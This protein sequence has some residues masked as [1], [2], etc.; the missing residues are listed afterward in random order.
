M[1][2]VAFHTLGCK[3]NFSETSTIARALRREGYE[4]VPFPGPADV[5]VLNTCSVTENAD[6][7]CKSLVRKV[8]R[9]SPDAFIAI[10]GCYAQLKPQEIAAIPG[11][12]L[13]L[14]AS[15][16]FKLLHH[17]KQ[18]SLDGSVAVHA[19]EVEAA[20]TFVSAWSQGGRTRTF[21]KVQDG[22]DYP[23][24][25]CTIPLARGISRSD[26]VQS[27]IEKTHEIAATGA[28]EIV[29]TG[30]N[31]GDFGKGEHG[32]KKHQHTFLQLLEQIEWQGADL[33]YR[34]SSIEPNLLSDDIISLVASSPKFMPH[35]HM[36]LQS[37]SDA[38]LGLMKRRYRTALYQARVEH[39][40]SVMPDASIGVDVISGFPGE[41]DERF[42][43]TL[44][45][46]HRLPVSYLHAFTYSE[47][48]NTP[49]AA[50]EGKVPAEI[51]TRRTNI[52]R[53][54]SAEKQSLFYSSASG[55]EAEVL[56]EADNRDGAMFGYTKNYIR[57]MTPY[58]LELAN[59]TQ[60]V[61]LQYHHAAEAMR[62][63]VIHEPQ[64][65]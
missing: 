31:I 39:I 32:N 34:I 24:S 13:V 2:T 42:E 6:K 45:F 43:E 38:I 54:L 22:C 18:A 20:D 59:T 41:T 50:M 53:E 21:L 27:I 47:R 30:V 26:T 17:L 5:V 28:K 48:A 63:Q 35:F 15:E 46:L 3:L 57:V 40:K 12:N 9:T 37:G 49:A 4:E 11:V 8:N 62:A 51:R 33:R 23:C 19:C 64:L 14:G 55:R 60:R 25:Y 61:R 29:L 36:P 44:N 65:I 52:L 1:K 58:H 10:V 16:K 7:E 56:W